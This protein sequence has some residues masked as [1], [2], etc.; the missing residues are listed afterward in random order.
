MPTTKLFSYNIEESDGKLVITI[1][2]LYA[3]SAI[4]QL[5][6]EVSTGRGWGALSR[7]S[8]IRALNRLSYESSRAARRA[9][10]GMPSS[11]GGGPDL[12]TIFKQGF[13]ETADDFSQHLD[14]FAGSLLELKA[15][16]EANQSKAPPTPA[17]PEKKAAK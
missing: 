15:E 9:A 11:G 8:P 17:A 16:F 4:Q 10:P 12:E 5:K 7:V 14:R 3:Q 6:S 13:S 2:G 1:D